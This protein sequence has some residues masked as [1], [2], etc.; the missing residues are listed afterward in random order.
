VPKGGKSRRDR[1]EAAVDLQLAGR[2]LEAGDFAAALPLL[3]R[4]ASILDSPSIPLAM[5]DCFKALG[6]RAEAERAYADA[7]ERRPQ[8]ADAHLRLAALLAE[9]G[10]LA[11]SL[12]HLRAVPP[13]RRDVSLR[14][15]LAYV[16]LQVGEW[17]EAESAAQSI[18]EAAKVQTNGA[19]SN[20]QVE[21]AR[22]FLGLAQAGQGRFGD[23]ARSLDHPGS[24]ERGRV[25]AARFHL[26]GGDL[27]R[28]LVLFSELA[29]RGQLSAGDWA[30][31]ALAAGLAG[32][33]EQAER[34]LQ[35]A[36]REAPSTEVRLAAAQLALAAHRPAE[37]LVSLDALENTSPLPDD[38]R[39]LS[40]VLRTR[41]LRLLDRPLEATHILGTSS[42]LGG[43]SPRVMALAELERG[44]LRAAEGDFEAAEKHF[45]SVLES[46]PGSIEAKDALDRARQKLSWKQQVLS[47]AER[48]VE[49]ARAEAE[50]L[51]HQFAA[52]ESELSALRRELAELERQRREAERQARE[53]REQA[54]EARRRAEAERQDALRREL[55][56]REREV[57]AKVTEEVTL[58][59]GGRPELAP[60]SLVEAL[61]VA[62]RNYQVGLQ[63]DLPGAGVAV[64]FSG[65]LER[66]LY[67]CLVLEFERHLDRVGGRREALLLA[68]RRSGRNGR[69]EYADNFVGAFDRDHPMRAPGLGEVARA[70]RKR[71]ESHLQL[72]K[73]FLDERGWD[74]TFLDALEKFLEQSKVRLRDPIAHGR[75][76][77]VDAKELAEFRRALMKEFAG[78][79]GVLARL[80]FPRGAGSSAG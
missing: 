61:A 46:D 28:A 4:C 27:S 5:G 18:V 48:A 62:E 25:L 57:R 71:S 76:I 32:Q 9:G 24:A 8:D 75:S 63:T 70:L 1:G 6:R 77:E 13:S 16:A 42:A 72:L 45:A 50:A 68:S 26:L 17:S 31:A 7:I 55:D 58:A 43:G 78:G 80:A 47:E 79:P 52:R 64:L 19:V 33:R 12:P 51:R 34:F 29:E 10:R 44:H 40:V 15:M 53:A 41:A 65:A 21:Q 3:E 20:E 37:A 67:V 74:S 73:E 22:L 11:E 60:P 39:A 59:F 35:R 54:E 56:E 69:F 66:G 30:P 14:S 23:A 38:D 36:E 49:T 2:L